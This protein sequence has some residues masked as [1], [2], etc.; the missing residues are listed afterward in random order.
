M[1]RVESSALA[2][3]KPSTGRRIGAALVGGIFGFIFG[4]GPGLFLSQTGTL[5]MNSYSSLVAPVGGT[6]L[7]ILVGWTGGRARKA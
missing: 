2:H 7:G 5:D 4:T 6:L 1:A 3:R